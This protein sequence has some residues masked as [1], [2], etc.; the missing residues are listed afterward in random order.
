ML[1][2]PNNINYH[3]TVVNLLFSI[4]YSQF[5]EYI[6]LL[7]S[8]L[9]TKYNIQFKY[10]INYFYCKIC[11][12]IISTTVY[13]QIKSFHNVKLDKNDID[14]ICKFLKKNKNITYEVVE[15]IDGYEIIKGFQSNIFEYLVAEKNSIRRYCKKKHIKVDYCKCLLQN[16]SNTCLKKYIRVRG[17][18]IKNYKTTIIGNELSKDILKKNFATIVSVK[19]K[20]NMNVFCNTLNWFTD[21]YNKFSDVDKK[22]IVSIS[23]LSKMNNTDIMDIFKHSISDF[24]NVD[25]MLRLIVTKNLMEESKPFTL[26]STPESIYQYIFIYTKLIFTMLIIHL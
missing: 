26:L 8:C 5:L 19:Y 3:D 25:F 16:I 22:E 15:Q 9:Y 21:K 1:L 13:S 18:N 17:G 23:K 24:N 20:K 14:T 11:N 7:Y 4:E 10:Q 2:I 6:L 12:I